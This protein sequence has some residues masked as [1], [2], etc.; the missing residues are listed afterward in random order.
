MKQNDGVFIPCDVFYARPEANVG[1]C[2]GLNN[3][4][5]SALLGMTTASP[6]TRWE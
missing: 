3:L 2:S 4:H 6:T 5:T 1:E